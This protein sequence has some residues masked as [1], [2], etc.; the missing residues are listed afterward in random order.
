MHL[1]LVVLRE[2]H[3]TR[4]SLTTRLLRITRLLLSPDCFHH[5][6]ATI[7]RLPLTALL[8]HVTR[9][10]PTA[11]RE[12]CR[13]LLLAL[14]GSHVRLGLGPHVHLLPLLLRGLL[15]PEA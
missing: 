8:L 10:P 9:L 14:L 3:I 6:A 12:L 11:L 5:Q 13:G 4:L 1:L 15:L 7:T 2:L